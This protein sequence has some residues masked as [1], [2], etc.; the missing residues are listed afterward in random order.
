M[1]KTVFLDRDGVINEPAA[2]HEYIRRWEDFHFIPG[3]IEAIRAL[4]E[5]GYQVIVVTNQRG[6]ARGMF[7]QATLDNLHQK[8][9]DALKEHQ[10]YLDQIYVCPHNDNECTCRKPQIGLFLAAE[11]EFAIDKAHSWM[12]GDS[13]TDI[14][15][16]QRYGIRTILIAES[17]TQLKTDQVCSSLSAAVNYLRSIATCKY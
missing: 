13:L 14:Q 17:D 8:L 1:S 9:Q 6:I 10:T 2:P 15:A 12:I 5:D 7:T 11:R 4:H 3:S 16:G